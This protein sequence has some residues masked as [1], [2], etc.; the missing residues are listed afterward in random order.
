MHFSSLL[1]KVLVSSSVVCRSILTCV[2][3]MDGNE[4]IWLILELLKGK[5]HL[6]RYHIGIG[7]I[8]KRG[9]SRIGRSSE[10]MLEISFE[11]KSVKDKER[12]DGK[13]VRPKDASLR[14]GMGDIEQ[15]WWR[16]DQ[17]CR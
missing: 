10:S 1:G 12:N 9:P 13:L 11:Q 3:L 2:K 8:P 14:S 15:K 6:H 17:R 16:E 5:N 7:S 4:L